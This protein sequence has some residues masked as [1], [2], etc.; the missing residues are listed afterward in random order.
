MKTT[1]EKIMAFRREDKGYWKINLK[2]V[3]LDGLSTDG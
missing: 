2:L 1:D 3:W